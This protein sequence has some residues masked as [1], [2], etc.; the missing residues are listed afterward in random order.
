MGSWFPPFHFL[1]RVVG[2]SDHWNADNGTNDSHSQYPSDEIEH[3][4]EDLALRTRLMTTVRA[5]DRFFSNL[6]LA[7]QA[8]IAHN[9]Y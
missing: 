2:D 3:F 5:G 9:Q 7:L 6:R 4:S 1:P 8:C